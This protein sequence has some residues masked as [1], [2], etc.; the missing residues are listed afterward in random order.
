MSAAGLLGPLA[1]PYRRPLAVGTGFALLEVAAGL[2]QPWPLKHVVDHVLGAPAGTRP[3]GGLALAL[4]A[5][6]A[7]VGVAATADY[8]AT[9]LLSAPGLHIAND[10]RDDV[11]SHLH[12]MSLRFHGEHRVGDLTARVTGD[13][14]RSQELVVQSL[15]V[16]LPN[17]LLMIGMVGVLFLLDPW[18]ALVALASTPILAAVVFRSTR[19]LKSANRSARKADGEVAAA[20]TE[21][22]GA[23]QL[24]QVFSLEDRQRAQFGALTRTSLGSALEATRLQ[25]RFSPIV[26]ITSAISTASVLGIGALR[27]MDG[28]LSVGELLVVLSYVGSVYKP[29]KALAK[30]SHTFSKG[31]TSVERIAAVLDSCPQIEDAGSIRL[32]PVH[33]RIELRDVDFSYGREQ[34]L[35]GV[36]LT[37]EPGETIALVGPTGAG[38]STI[39]SLIPRLVDPDAGTVLVDGHDL[40]SVSVRSLRAQVSMVLQDCVL[41]R[42]TLRE[43]IAVGRIGATGRDIERA[44]R[45]A[46]VDEFA[47]RMPLGLD[48]P[49]GERGANLSGGQ[50]QRIAIARA[51]LR[52]AP[53]LILDE[54]TSALDPASEALIIEALSNLP[55]GRTAIVI[56]HRLTTIEHADRIVVVEGGRIVDQGDHGQLMARGGTYRDFRTGNRPPAPLP[57]P[58]PLLTPFFIS[59][60]LLDAARRS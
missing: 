13:A 44:A 29:V 47:S 58:A 25:A 41:L 10:L 53:I 3:I 33:G 57:A 31:V 36:N 14:D 59:S 12:R 50:R 6:L 24:V 15:A 37:I 52:D 7:V 22:L 39:A 54:P 46:L 16:L 30:L 55:S 34:A 18:L 60:P 4:V 8:W 19:Q 17:A 42:G 27:V 35:S 43:N 49:V 1:R 51:I 38:K 45:L 21:S 32:P 2:A 23:M 40:R 9:R 20:T 28:E 26:D 11:F 48:T 5:L 56:A